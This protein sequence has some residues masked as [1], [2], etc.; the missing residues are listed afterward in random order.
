M[1]EPLEV[2]GRG[3]WLDFGHTILRGEG[4]LTYLIRVDDAKDVRIHGGELRSGRWGLLI[5]GGERVTISDLGMEGLVGGGV[6]V[7]NAREPILWGLRLTRLGAAGMLVQG[8]TRHGVIGASEI[9]HDLGSENW[10]AGIVLSDRNANLTE[11]PENLLRLP[12]QRITT[13]L[14]IPMDNVIWHNRISDNR[15]SGIYSDGG[16]RDVYVGNR[17]E[18]NAKEGFCLDNGSTANVVAYNQINGN[19]RRGGMTDAELKRD[20]VEKVG[21][22]SDGSSPAKVPGMSLDNAIY[23][24]VLLNEVDGNYGS[25][26]KMVRTAFYNLVAQN[27]LVSD[28]QG[29][30]AIFHFFGIELGSARADTTVP[31]LNFAPSRGNWLFGNVIRGS[32]YAGVFFAAG[33]DQN[34]VARNTISGATAWSMESVEKQDEWVRGNVMDGRVRNVVL[35]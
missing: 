32:H 34:E 22:L 35:Q 29:Q 10:Q 2:R 9:T 30:S 27:T 7:T 12:D 14:T 26:I 28:N 11:D 19:G 1:D 4:N 6:V 17:I 16:A 23:N 20:Y 33:S 15:A 31:D 8:R 3:L 25:G 18:G 13:R 24:Q 5:A 21:R